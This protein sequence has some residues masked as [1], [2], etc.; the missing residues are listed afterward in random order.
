MFDQ[1]TLNAKLTSFAGI[2][3]FVGFGW[4]LGVMSVCAVAWALI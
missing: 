3:A 1:E 4:L 2:L